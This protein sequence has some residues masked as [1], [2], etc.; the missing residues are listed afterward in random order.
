MVSVNGL[1]TDTTKI[2]GSL[3]GPFPDGIAVESFG[4]VTVNGTSAVVIADVGYTLGDMV[5]FGNTNF[6]GTPNIAPYLSAGTTGTGFSVKAQASD[7][8]IYNWWRFSPSAQ[9]G[10]S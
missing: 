4:T 3:T 5:V 6:A 10:N 9:L 8:G 1:N 2:I 7:T